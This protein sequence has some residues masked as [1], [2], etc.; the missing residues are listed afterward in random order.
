MYMSIDF[1]YCIF[2]GEFLLPPSNVLCHTYQYLHA[3]MKDIGME[4]Q[5]IHACPDDN[6]L[7]YGEH[8]SKEE[9]QKFQISK[10]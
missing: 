6:I 4:Y 8:A 1:L 5:V 3:I 7:Y 10:Y 2:L 9:F